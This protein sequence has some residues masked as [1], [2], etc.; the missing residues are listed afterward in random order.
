MMVFKLSNLIEEMHLLCQGRVRP[1]IEFTPELPVFIVTPSKHKFETI[2]PYPDWGGGILPAQIF[3]VYSIFNKQANATKL[4]LFL[5][6]NWEQFGVVSPCLTL[7]W[8]PPFDK[9]FFS[10]FS[11]SL[12][13]IK[14][15]YFFELN[16]TFL[17]P[18]RKFIDFDHFLINFGGFE[19]F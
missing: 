6:F 13:L 12:F 10:E 11:I 9:R 2:Y 15:H 19:G 5:K 4:G 14:N 7:L 18:F 3:H 1:D 16:F 8:Q 17:D